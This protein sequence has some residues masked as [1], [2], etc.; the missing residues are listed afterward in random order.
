MIKFLY[1]VIMNKRGAM[2][3]FYAVVTHY[4]WH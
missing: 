1:C 3:L 4:L 2:V